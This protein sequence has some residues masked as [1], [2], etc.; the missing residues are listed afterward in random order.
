MTIHLFSRARELAGTGS[1][2]VPFPPGATV[3]ALRA[4]LAEQ[5]PPLRELLA[6]SRIAV[7]HDFAA[8]TAAIQDTDEVA[9]IPPV[10]GG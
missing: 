6:V 2:D 10:S 4:R 3:A 5:I 1:V 8:D 7:N 9:V